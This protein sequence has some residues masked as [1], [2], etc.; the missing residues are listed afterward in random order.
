MKS[1][2]HFVELAITITYYGVGKT[3]QEAKQNAINEFANNNYDLF[4]SKDYKQEI[5]TVKRF[6]T[7]L[8]KSYIDFVMNDN[9]E[10]I[11]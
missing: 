5:N 4:Q 3:L 7:T 11:K 8:D 6:N 10:E 9:Y 2:P 1:K